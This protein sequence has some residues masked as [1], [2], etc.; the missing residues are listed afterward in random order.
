M[1]LLGKNGGDPKQKE[2]AI[3]ICFLENG[4]IV[5]EPTEALRQLERERRYMGR[6]ASGDCLIYHR[7]H[8]RRQNEGIPELFLL[9][10][11]REEV[12]C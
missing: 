8:L 2:S 3:A 12:V 11:L 6:F 4:E 10:L 5:V 1:N 9:Q 7:I